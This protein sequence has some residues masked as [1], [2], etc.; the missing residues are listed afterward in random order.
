MCVCVYLFLPHSSKCRE[1]RPEN[2]MLNDGGPMDRLCYVNLAVQM[3]DSPMD[4]L[5]YV[6]LDRP[7]RRRSNGPPMLCQFGPSKRTPVQWTVVHLDGPLDRLYYGNLD[8]PKLRLWTVILYRPK[9]RLWTVIF[10]RPK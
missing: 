6:N 4:R 7:N 5:C 3:D 9:I 1:A 8:L 2:V 10:Y